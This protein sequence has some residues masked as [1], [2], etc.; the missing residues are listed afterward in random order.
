MTNKELYLPIDIL[1]RE[2]RKDDVL[3][4][5]G[6]HIKETFHN[7]LKELPPPPPGYM[8]V[9]YLVG[10]DPIISSDGSAVFAMEI[11]LE[12]I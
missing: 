5:I 2:D 11:H 12:R 7:K 1:E 8:Y 4:M 9:P 10:D 6:Q 3:E